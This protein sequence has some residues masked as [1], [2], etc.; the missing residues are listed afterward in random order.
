MCATPDGAFGSLRD[1][2]L[3]AAP[4]SLLSTREL[5]LLRLPSPSL[6]CGTRPCAH[7]PLRPEPGRA[8][9]TDRP[10]RRRRKYAYRTPRIVLSTRDLARSLTSSLCISRALYSSGVGV[11]TSRGREL[12]SKISWSAM[13]A[14]FTDVIASGVDRKRLSASGFVNFFTNSR[15]SDTYI[16]FTVAG[17]WSGMPAAASRIDNGCVDNLAPLSTKVS[18]AF[19]NFSLAS[20][21]SS[22]ER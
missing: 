6:P 12:A 19:L 20:A 18:K 11:T 9:R 22:F 8:S 5:T 14:N 16:S 2:I 3:A 1:L 21:I 7:F 17:T 15:T 10:P 13:S 4:S